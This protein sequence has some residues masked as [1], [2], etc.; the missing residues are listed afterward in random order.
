MK[1]PRPL[2]PQQDMLAWLAQNHPDLLKTVEPDR[3]WLWVSADLRK[4]KATRE[5]LKQLGFRFA[6]KGHTTPSGKV[7]FWGHCCKRPTPFK[8]NS[9]SG[10]GPSGKSTEGDSLMSEIDQLLQEAGVS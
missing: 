8:K 6:R 2:L 3:D 7:A 10:K 5:S 9:G 4:D 1:I